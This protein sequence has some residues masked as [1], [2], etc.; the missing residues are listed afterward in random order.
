MPDSAVPRQPLC[1]S[2][3]RKFRRAG[4]GRHC[5]FNPL[6]GPYS[7]SVADI[8]KALQNSLSVVAAYSRADAL[9]DDLIFDFPNRIRVDNLKIDSNELW[10]LRRSAK[11]QKILIGIAHAASDGV[12]VGTVDHVMVLPSLQNQGLGRR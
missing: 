9:P 5:K 1:N 10:H 8:T 4:C 12:F 11:R 7:A 6:A 2:Q 3:E